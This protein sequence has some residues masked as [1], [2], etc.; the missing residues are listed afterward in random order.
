MRAGGKRCV[1]A[2]LLPI[3]LANSL[4]ASTVLCIAQDI[5]PMREGG[6]RYVVA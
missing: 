5:P 4:Y 6:K 3:E 1:M 2:W